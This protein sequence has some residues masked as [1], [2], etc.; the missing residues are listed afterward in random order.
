[1]VKKP[2]SLCIEKTRMVLHDYLQLKYI[3]ENYDTQKN[4]PK[5]ASPLLLILKCTM[6]HLLVLL[7]KNHF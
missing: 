4:Y 2:I 5:K 3:F 6:E 7:L 1:M